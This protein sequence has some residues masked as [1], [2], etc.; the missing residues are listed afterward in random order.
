[1][2]NFLNMIHT[3]FIKFNESIEWFVFHKNVWVYKT[4]IIHLI[5]LA[6][7][8]KNFEQN[9]ANAS[10]AKA[11]CPYLY[12]VSRGESLTKAPPHHH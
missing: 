6:K 5:K 10:A 2:E 12:V 7:Q 4:I 9:K 8:T 3:Y 11:R 1:M